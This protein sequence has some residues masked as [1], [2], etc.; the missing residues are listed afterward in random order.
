[1]ANILVVDDEKNIQE[2]VSYN[3]KKEGHTVSTADDGLSGL[4]EALS[5]TYD[6]IV[7]DVML[8]GLDGTEVCRKLRDNETT[9][10]IP[11]I[12]L[13]AR[14]EEVDRI[15]GLEFGADDYVVKPFSPRELSARVKAVLR[16][17]GDREEESAESAPNDIVKGDIILNPQKREITVKGEAKYFTPKEYA[18]L[19]LLMINEGQAFSREFLLEKI[20]GYDYLGDTRTVDVHVRHLRQKIEDDPANP[21]Y[22]QTVRSYGY[23]FKGGE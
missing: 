21:Q 18:L 2:L 9:R 14:G 23:K 8:P 11:V 4:Q 15:I 12:M 20:W 22:I 17:A 19:E 1:M 16:R 3:L 6:L 5:G 13:S 10:R 7:L